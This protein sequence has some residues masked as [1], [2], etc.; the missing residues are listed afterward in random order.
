MCLTL[1]YHYFHSAKCASA[2]IIWHRIPS[3]LYHTLS[4]TFIQQNAQAQPLFGI[5]Y[6]GA[7]GIQDHKKVFIFAMREQRLFCSAAMLINQT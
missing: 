7:K 4:L 3:L 6:L 5:E 2:A 1:L